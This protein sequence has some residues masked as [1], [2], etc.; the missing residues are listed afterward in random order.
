VSGWERAELNT[1]SHPEEVSLVFRAIV[2]KREPQ[3]L[4]EAT[5]EDRLLAKTEIDALARLPLWYRIASEGRD[6][7]AVW[8]KVV[9]VS[10]G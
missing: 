4:R 9:R 5:E 6:P 7:V 1:K 10:N 3:K 8:M 2:K